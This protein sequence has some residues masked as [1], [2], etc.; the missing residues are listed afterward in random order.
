MPLSYSIRYRLLSSL[1]APL[2]RVDVR[3]AGKY[4]LALALG[5]DSSADGRKGTEE[6]QNPILHTFSLILS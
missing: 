4:A 1:K 6:N 2:E 5:M 3:R